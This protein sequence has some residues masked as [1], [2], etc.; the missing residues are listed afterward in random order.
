MSGVHNKV[1]HTLKV[2][3][4]M[5]QDSSMYLIILWIPGIIRMFQDGGLYDIKTS[6]WFAEQINILVSMIETSVMKELNKNFELKRTVMQIG[7]VL[8]NMSVSKVPWEFRIATTY[9]F[10]VIYPWNLLFAAVYFLTVSIVF[11]IY[12]QNFTAQWLKN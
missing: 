11:S 1:K 6:P 4:Q 12:K 2:F 3:K 5:L 8:R 10:A 7:K 9:N